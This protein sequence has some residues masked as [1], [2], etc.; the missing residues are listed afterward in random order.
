[1]RGLSFFTIFLF[2]FLL[3]A[4]TST[5]GFYIEK[6]KGVE[7]WIIT[8]DKMVEKGKIK[9]I[10]NIVLKI[11]RDKEPISVRG[12]KAL[13]EEDKGFKVEEGSINLWG[14]LIRGK[15][16]IWKEGEDTI[17]LTLPFVVEDK[18]WSLRGGRGEIDLK[19]KILRISKGVEWGK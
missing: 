8:G 11:L 12:K 4:D 14:K 13:Y 16:F 2:A 7:K 3:F 15:E 18:G 9:E 17:K 1:M 6:R 5:E 10:K 19:D